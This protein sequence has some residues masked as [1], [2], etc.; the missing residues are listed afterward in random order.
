MHTALENLF[1]SLPRFSAHHSLSIVLSPS[2]PY[3]TDGAICTFRRHHYQLQ[4]LFAIKEI[5]EFHCSTSPN[6][7]FSLSRFLF[8]PLS[9]SLSFSV[10][11]DEPT[12]N[13]LRE[14]I[15]REKKCERGQTG[16]MN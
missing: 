14:A 7:L 1:I 16:V 4:S 13:S 12:K 11:L 10:A 9:L 8:L 15:V 6:T 5:D 2:I 3:E